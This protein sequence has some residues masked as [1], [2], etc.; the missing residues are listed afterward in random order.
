MIFCHLLTDKLLVW[1]AFA[2]YTVFIATRDINPNAVVKANL[3]V[4]LCLTFIYT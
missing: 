3:E 4:N 1:Q 2:R